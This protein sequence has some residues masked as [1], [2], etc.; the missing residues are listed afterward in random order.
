MIL[1]SLIRASE[2]AFEKPVLWNTGNFAILIEGG[3]LHPE[4]SLK[5]IE[6]WADQL[7]CANI[8]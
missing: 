4:V 3:K 7:L 6:W 1:Q 2:E 8:Q 5:H